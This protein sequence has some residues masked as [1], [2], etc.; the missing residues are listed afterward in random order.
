MSRG[1]AI[2]CV[3]LFGS[4]AGYGFYELIVVPYLVTEFSCEQLK[5]NFHKDLA[6]KEWNKRCVLN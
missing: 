2:V 1:Y 5:N 4:L 3:I 6:V